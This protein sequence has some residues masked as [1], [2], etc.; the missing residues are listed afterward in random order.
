MHRGSHQFQFK[1]TMSFIYGKK[2]AY[3]LPS[4]F[5]LKD[6]LTLDIPQKITQPSWFSQNNFMFQKNLSEFQTLKAVLDS[7]NLSYLS[8]IWNQGQLWATGKGTASLIKLLCY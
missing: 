6:F 7:L 4:N 8:A 2:S 3:L 1:P 5:S